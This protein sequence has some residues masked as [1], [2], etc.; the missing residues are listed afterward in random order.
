MGLLVRWRSNS[1][2][3][4]LEGERW[5]GGLVEPRIGIGSGLFDHLV[6][7]Y[8]HR[9]GYIDAERLGGLEVKYQFKFR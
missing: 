5:R 9:K 1:T 6:G 8:L 4:I 2:S 3:R 7:K